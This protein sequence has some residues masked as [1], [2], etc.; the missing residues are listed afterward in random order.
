MQ[1][2]MFGETPSYWLIKHVGGGKK[3]QRS[4]ICQMGPLSYLLITTEGPEQSRDGGFT[5]PELGD[6]AYAMGAKNAF[7]LDGG[8]SAW[9][10]LGGERIN[11]MKT[12]NIQKISDSIYFVTAVPEIPSKVPATP[13]DTAP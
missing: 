12:R 4:A 9:L 13:T 7:N 5:I 1:H 8:S 10:V 2:D 6:L 11:T 3:T